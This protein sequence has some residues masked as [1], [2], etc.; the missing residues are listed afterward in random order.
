MLVSKDKSITIK[1]AKDLRAYLMDYTY[2]AFLENFSNVEKNTVG[3][4][5]KMEDPEYVA[6][7]KTIALQRL[8]IE[9]IMD[10]Y[11]VSQST[12]YRMRREAKAYEE[13]Q[14]REKKSYL[15]YQRGQ[16][17]ER[18]N[19]YADFQNYSFCMMAGPLKKAPVTEP[20]KEKRKTRSFCLTDSTYQHLLN[21]KKEM[22]FD[23][24]TS[25]FL[26]YI[27]DRM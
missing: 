9:Q 10:M 16:E 26:S 8:T 20:K 1:T 27:I 11:K 21:K 24:S 3:R 2:D 15:L 22:G 5:P 6:R 23:G 19:R 13:K 25:D 18:A 4:K 14:I 12:A 17:K 7:L